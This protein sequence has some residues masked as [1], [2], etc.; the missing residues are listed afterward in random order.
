MSL[1]SL[2]QFSLNFFCESE[3]FHTAL[4]IS[5]NVSDFIDE[6]LYFG[7]S[8]EK[9][10]LE[11]ARQHCSKRNGTLVT[12]RTREKYDQVVDYLKHWL[13]NANSFQFYYDTWLNMLIEPDVSYFGIFR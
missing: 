1:H 9:K 8:L 11:E 10:T 3:F 6:K 4:A 7:S 12:I 13:H 2:E 5:I